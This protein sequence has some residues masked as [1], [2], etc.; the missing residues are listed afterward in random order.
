MLLLLFFLLL[1]L[2]LGLD[3]ETRRH[4]PWSRR[5]VIKVP[6]Q[7]G[8]EGKRNRK[9]KRKRKRSGRR[10]SRVNGRLWVRV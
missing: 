4:S 9:K 10:R 2:L 6:R 5:K 8:A 7:E 3:T 1:M